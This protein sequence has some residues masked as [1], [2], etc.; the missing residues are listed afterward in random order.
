MQEPQ[1]SSSEMFD[2]HRRS[3]VMQSDPVAGL[4]LRI[5]AAVETTYSSCLN[6]SIDGFMYDACCVCVMY[7]PPAMISRE[8]LVHI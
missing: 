5:S 1:L 4:P 7:V 8:S 2:I 6:K 3:F